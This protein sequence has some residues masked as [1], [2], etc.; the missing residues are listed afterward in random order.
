M[1]LE[2]VNGG[3]WQ[4]A[5]GTYETIFETYW[6]LKLRSNSKRLGRPYSLEIYVSPTWKWY[7]NF[8]VKMDDW[9]TTLI[10][11]FNSKYIKNAE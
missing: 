3:G 6:T 9:A 8:W 2:V 5:K 1:S 4:K 7:K 11:L 10:S